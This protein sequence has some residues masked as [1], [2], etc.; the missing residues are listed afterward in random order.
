MIFCLIYVCCIFLAA[1]ISFVYALLYCFEF[2][3]W[4]NSIHTTSPKFC[5]HYKCVYCFSIL[6]RCICLKFNC[7]NNKFR[8]N[9]ADYSVLK[10][11]ANFTCRAHTKF[12]LIL[13]I[14]YLNDCA[15]QKELIYSSGK[16]CLLICV[17]VHECLYSSIIN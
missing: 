12:N 16:C 14:L 2:G 10:D 8:R 6:P 5:L 9:P 11:A 15:A 1:I 13:Y 4:L 7:K 3:G 17:D